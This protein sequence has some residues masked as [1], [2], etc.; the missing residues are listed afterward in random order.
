MDIVV[1]AVTPNRSEGSPIA[2]LGLQPGGDV[3]I[4][5]RDKAFI[6]PRFNAGQTVWS[7]HNR[8][9]AEYVVAHDQN[10]LQPVENPHFTF[11]PPAYFHLRANNDQELWV[12]VALIEIMITQDVS[13]PWVR[14]VSRPIRE[15]QARPPRNPGRT[16]VLPVPVPSGDVSVGVAIDFVRPGANDPTGAIAEQYFDSGRYRLHASCELLPMQ[17]PT[18]AWFHQY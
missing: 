2:W 4:G 18:L 9:T 17:V 12:G 6:S 15:I 16:T 5:L 14:L 7:L 13:V 8:F 3:S 10:A 11:H 1:S